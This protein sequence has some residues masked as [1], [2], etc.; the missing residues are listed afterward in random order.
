MHVFIHHP[1]VS[2]KNHVRHALPRLEQRTLFQRRIVPVRMPGTYRVRP[3]GFSEPI[4]VRQLDTNRFGRPDHGWRRRR[5]CDH[6]LYLRTETNA[7]AR[8]VLTERAHYHG[9]TAEM[10]DTLV[11]DQLDGTLGVHFG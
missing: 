2:P 5:G 4:D 11:L 1:H 3:I 6:H 9:R 10:S 7:I 8:T